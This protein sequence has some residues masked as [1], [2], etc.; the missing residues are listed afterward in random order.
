MVSERWRLSTRNASSPPSPPGLRLTS[1]GRAPGRR[2]DLGERDGMQ[3]GVEL[4]VAGP[5]QPV[6]ARFDDYTRSG[7]VPVWR[8]RHLGFGT[9]AHQGSRPESWLR[10]DIPGL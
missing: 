5:G 4:E 3:D 10:L 6:S 2:C 7:A 9:V 8:R 1:K